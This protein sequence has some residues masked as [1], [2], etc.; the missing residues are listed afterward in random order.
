MTL[1]PY[2]M[3]SVGLDLRDELLEFRTIL[4]SDCVI[5]HSELHPSPTCGCEVQSAKLATPK[6]KT[7][8][9]SRENGNT[10]FVLFIHIFA[11]A[12]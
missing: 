3:E 1:S 4:N 11:S 12:K 5:V 8:C 9:N 6:N 2:Y 10:L 7:V